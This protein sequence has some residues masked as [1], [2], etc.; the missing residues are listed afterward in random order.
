MTARLFQLS[1]V[2]VD[3]I[4]DIP[5]LPAAG[6]EV[7]ST[8]FHTA[9][10]GGF[11]A[12]AAA[13]R[14]GVE[15]VYAG[16]LGTGTFSDIAAAALAAEGIPLAHADRAAMDQ[17]HCIALVDA[18]AERTFVSYHGAERHITEAQLAK[19]PVRDED[20]LL[21]TGYSLYK[22]SSAD[23]F[24]PWLRTLPRGP[25]L[26]FDPGPV[27]G[28][29]ATDILDI[30]MARADWVSVN[31]R[32]AST[33]T[34]ATQAAAAAEMLSQGRAG[35]IVRTGADGCWL[36]ERGRR[37]CHAPGFDIAVRDSN[38]AGDTHDGAFIAAMMAGFAPGQSAVFAN[39]AAALSTTVPGP[40]TCPRLR[41][42]NAF[43]SE[44]EREGLGG[45]L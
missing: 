19:L 14:L 8:N 4:Y 32:E 5:G 13:R 2:I 22:K 9:A 1:G 6:D 45:C 44:R 30:A 34:G 16:S 41:A 26:L 15:V 39:A 10:G 36:S 38:G 42:V 21:L 24:V 12:A 7:E 20:W 11:N 35:A 3:L 17:G 40:A 43:L 29:I 33:L 31:A 18:R 28:G 25:R 23:V 37:V 27:V